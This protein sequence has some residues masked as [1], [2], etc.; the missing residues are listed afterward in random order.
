M[1]CGHCMQATSAETQ[2]PEGAALKSLAPG[3]TPCRTGCLSTAAMLP[4]STKSYVSPG[5]QPL[6]PRLRCCHM[7]PLGYLPR[8]PRADGLHA[9]GLPVLQQCRPRRQELPTCW[10]QCRL[11]PLAQLGRSG[12]QRPLALSRGRLS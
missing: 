8:L 1:S 7:G 9:G 4:G 6:A 5:L 11:Q 3:S 12:W 10:P 2:G